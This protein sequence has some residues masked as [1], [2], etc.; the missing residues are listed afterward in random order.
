MW[1]AQFQ[2]RVCMCGH[3]HSPSGSAPGVTSAGQL[4]PRVHTRAPERCPWTLRRPWVGE[5]MDTV[6]AQLDSNHHCW[7]PVE[8]C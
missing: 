3:A 4:W 8:C 2:T 1:R 7:W 5:L 6:P